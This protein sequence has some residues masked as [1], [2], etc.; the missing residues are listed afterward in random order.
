MDYMASFKEIS[1]QQLEFS[2]KVLRCDRSM[3]QYQR[4]ILTSRSRKE[5]SF[6][7]FGEQHS[8]V[9]HKGQKVPILIREQGK[10]RVASSATTL[11]SSTINI[12]AGDSLS[13]SCVV[14]F[15]MTSDNRGFYLTNTEYSSFDLQNPDRIVVRVNA[16][17]MTAR[18]IDGSSLLDLLT[19]YTSYAG[20]AQPLPS[21]VGQGAIAEIQGGEEKVRHIVQ[22][23]R[24][25]R[26]PLAALCIP[27]WTGQLQSVQLQQQ[28]QPSYNVLGRTCYT[29]EHDIRT[30][31]DW[32]NLI[33][34]LTQKTIPANALSDGSNE[35]DTVAATLAVTTDD[36]NVG[37]EE[38]KEDM[39]IPTDTI[40]EQQPKTPTSTT[41]VRVLVSISPFL[42]ELKNTT[43]QSEFFDQ[44][45]SQGYLVQTTG[46][47]TYTLSPQPGNHVGMVDLSNPDA[48][49]WL[50][51]VLKKQV[52]D[53]GISGYLADYGH[54]LPMDSNHLQ[55]FSKK[56]ALTYHNQYAEDW[57]KLHEELFKEY[58]LDDDN[59]VCFVRSGFTRSPGKI[60]SLWTG[61]HNVSWDQHD[62]IKSAVTAMITAGLSGFSVS[63]CDIGGYITAD[64]GM[65]GTRMTR[66][67]ELL[68][69][70]MELA[71][72]TPVF[73]TSEGLIP[74]SNAQ[75]YDNEE[76]YMQ[77]AHTAELFVILAPYR[78]QLFKDAKSKGWPLVR[79]LVLYYPQDSVVQN[80][81]WQQFL[82]GS[83]LMVA[84]TLSPVAYVKVYFP[85]DNRNITWRHI[86]TG[87]T[88]DAD[89]SYHAV[90]TP[91]GQP[92]AFVME[93]RDDQPGATELQQL[94]KFASSY[95][96]THTTT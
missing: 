44:A 55:L 92:A 68:H 70:W 39:K 6:Y 60:Q 24:D 19:E 22:Q 41:P 35:G 11:W 1:P 86:W 74:R 88:Y 94:L 42:S 34:D 77:L 29:F 73:R 27:D 14:P 80:M 37:N 63:H 67:R 43:K 16:T 31:P 47:T 32:I 21:W 52:F 96:D 64:G 50:K 36:D 87:K 58:D 48:R 71:A 95:H 46:H 89:G 45:S 85:K 65:L 53:N 28:Q 33:Q 49:Q 90:D 57:A 82:L 72:F 66:S 3:E 83:A 76:S 12:L 5:E 30:Y 79:H 25:H 62:G 4:L 51:S 17:T 38:D 8:S 84:P 26:V 15:Y 56:D 69:R 40:K 20:R 93:P 9:D 91:M 7:G 2:I 23:L 81:T 13:S 78:K 18:L 59:A 61:D 54:T 10:G 75:F